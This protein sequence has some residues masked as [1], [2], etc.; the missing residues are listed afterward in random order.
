MT[1]WKW[2]AFNFVSKFKRMEDERGVMELEVDNFSLTV[3]K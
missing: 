1:D 3:G 2:R